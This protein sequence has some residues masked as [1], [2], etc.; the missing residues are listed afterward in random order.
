M[1]KHHSDGETMRYCNICLQPDTRPG[2]KFDEEG[3]CPTCR[4]H[5]TLDK[6]SWSERWAELV[7]LIE[8]GRKNSASGYDC[9]IGVSG[10]KDSLRQCMFVRDVLKMRPLTICL[11][12]PPE[13][14][15]QRGVNNLAN[16]TN[17]GFDCLTIQP[18]PGI[19]RKLMRRDFLNMPTGVNLLN[20]HCSVVFRGWQ[21][22]IRSH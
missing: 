14:S 22:P 9:I 12:Y 19:W 21:L 7:D 20:W 16:L 13:Q 3:V 2:I 15:T 6:I 18:S 8:F 10:G 17:S 11:S 1:A 5:Q 4:Y